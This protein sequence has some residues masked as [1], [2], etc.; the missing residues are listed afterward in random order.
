MKRVLIILLGLCVAL[1]TAQDVWKS[2]A[3]AEGKFTAKMPGTPQ[4]ST[5]TYTEGKYSVPTTMYVASRANTNFVLTF[6]ILPKDAPA[7]F[8]TNLMTG[9]KKGFLNSVGGS[10]V[11]DK[12][13]GY[14]GVKGR[15]ITFKAPNGAQGVFWMFVKNGRFYTL[16]IG[17]KG[18]DYAAEQSKFF[19]SFYSRP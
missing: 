12:E 13:G 14:N 11:S 15:L 6:S 10:A 9:A 5:Q 16:T 2:V 1:A 8:S 17:K 18:G 4:M 19:G 7:E 3:P